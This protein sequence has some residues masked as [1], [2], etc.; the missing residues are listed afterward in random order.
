MYVYVFAYVC[1]DACMYVYWVG[2]DVCNSTSSVN[3]RLINYYCYR[4]PTWSYASFVGFCMCVCGCAHVCTFVHVCE[5]M[6]ELCLY[7][8]L[9]HQPH[10]MV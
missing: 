9:V 7:T 1:A 8:L 10:A 3:I 5:R 6:C 4:E 2:S